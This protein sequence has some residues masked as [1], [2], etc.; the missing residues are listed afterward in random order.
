MVRFDTMAGRPG[1]AAAARPG[2]QNGAQARAFR[3]IFA[4]IGRLPSAH[5]GGRALPLAPVPKATRVGVGSVLVQ[6]GGRTIPLGIAAVVLGFIL[7]L[8]G[9]Q[10]DPADAGPRG[11][12]V[13]VFGTI[14]PDLLRLA[15]PLGSGPRYD[16]VRVAALEPQF[17][18]D[19]PAVGLGMLA[20][21]SASACRAASPNAT[22]EERFAA[23][24]DGAVSFD[25]RFA[26]TDDCPSSFDE[27]LASAMQ[28]LA[29]SLRLP[30]AQDVRAD[31]PPKPAAT[32]A[33]ARV[34]PAPPRKAV[35]R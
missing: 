23:L 19:A 31:A 6:L 26:S 27:S 21:T 18:S 22:L 7:R 5:V 13:S 15:A 34:R 35:P 17:R 2:T 1:R 30:A 14:H 11:S 29:R 33:T 16:R 20:D 24:N 32:V 10:A 12:G 4:V 9:T 25:Q 3:T 8:P 28:A